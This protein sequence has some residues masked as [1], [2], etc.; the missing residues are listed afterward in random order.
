MP[1]KDN[2]NNP[3]QVRLKAV[4]VPPGVSP[5][6]YHQRLLQFIT[7]GKPL[8]RAWEVELWWR[9]PRTKHGVT[10]RWR[11][12]SFEDAISESRSGFVSIIYDVL[13]RRLRR[14]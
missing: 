10:K 7:E 13:V 11:S 14:M 2:S 5:R 12:D 8:P 1:R 4:S 6:R 9:N 3:L